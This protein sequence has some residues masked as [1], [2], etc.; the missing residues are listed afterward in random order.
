M[1]KISKPLSTELVKTYWKVDL[2]PANQRNYFR[3][4]VGEDARLEGEWHGKLCAHLGLVAGSGVGET[5]YKRM[6]QGLH[7]LTAE[8]LVKHRK[9]AETT[10]AW[11]KNDRAWR[12]RIESMFVDAILLH[13]S[14][15]LRTVPQSEYR[16]QHPDPVRPAGVQTSGGDSVRAGRL[17]EIHRAA[18]EHFRARLLAPENCQAREYLECRGISAESSAAF[19]LG[20]SSD[21]DE[22]GAQLAPQFAK[23]DLEGSGLFW[24]DGAG[25]LHDR[26]RNRIVIPIRD[27]AGDVIAFAGRS[28]DPTARDKY[29]N[30]PE[31]GIYKKS[32]VLFGLDRAKASGTGRVV[33]QEGYFDVIAA[34]SAGVTDAVALCGTAL[35][36]S[37]VAQVRAIASDVILNLDGG[38]AELGKGQAAQM[39]H[40]PVLLDAGLRVRA[41]NMEGDPDSFVRTRGADAYRAAI[42]QTR[43]LV[44]WLAEHV[45]ANDTFHPP[46]RT[47]QA[48]RMMRVLERV[49]AEDR[50]RT[51][52]ELAKYLR[53]EQPKEAVPKKVSHSEHVS[54]WDFTVAPHK[55]YSAAYCVGGD[56]RILEWHETA[57]RE[58]LDA[59]EKYTQARMKDIGG[60]TTQ[61]WAAALFVHDTARPVGGMA[62]NP[63]LYTHCVVFNMTRDEDGKIRSVASHE[64]FRI[65]SYMDAVY[66]AAMAEQAL[67]GGYELEHHGRS[68]ATC[69]KGFSK[70]YVDTISARTKEIEEEKLRLGIAGAEADERVNKRLRERKQEWDP[71]RCDSST[72]ARLPRWAR[73][74]RRLWA[75]RKRE[76]ANV[77]KERP[78]GGRQTWLSAL[79]KNGCKPRRLSTTISS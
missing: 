52:V 15:F 21:G 29:L 57:I 28:L 2:T 24:T 31:T 14:G 68:F 60:V 19:A 9:V 12:E 7:P 66:Q 1:I 41:V 4:G 8:V 40:I 76:W 18:A 62:P 26:F 64:W 27:A 20:L 38:T 39:R 56:R 43:P 36:A 3:E 54:A 17:R 13:G 77:W 70:E 11:V 53:V 51:S 48:R 55:S 63:H 35:S 75:R 30:S 32:D 71:K 34:H 74:R 22:L 49:T 79:P 67:A 44:E 59:G 61:N 45:R 6:A 73:T 69:I 65:Q 25:R 72:C 5:H 47:E 23:A 78:G 16:Y 58:M 42:D 50:E 33:L 46:D 10:P 37:Q